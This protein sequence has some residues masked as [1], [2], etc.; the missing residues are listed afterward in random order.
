VGDALGTSTWTVTLRDTTSET[1][2]KTFTLIY[3][4]DGYPYKTSAIDAVDPWDFYTRECTSY[5]AWR[6]NVDGIPFT[7]SYEFP[8]STPPNGWHNAVNWKS[9]AL[10]IGLTVD[11]TPAVGAVAWFGT[12]VGPAGHVAYVSS[13]TSN[14]N[15]VLEEYN[16]LTAYTYDTR[17]ISSSSVGAF[18]HFH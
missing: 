1:A 2:S 5:V 15:I 10:D 9:A 6:L 11:N 17:T 18:I 16:Y 12:S 4:A 7:N 8:N 14:G 3:S 13:I